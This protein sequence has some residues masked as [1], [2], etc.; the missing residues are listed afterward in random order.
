VNSAPL[1]SIVI[2]AFNPRFFQRA[3][4]GALG[5]TYAHLEVIVCD[6]SAGDEIERIVQALGATTQVDL[7][8]VRNPQRLG[9]V[10][11]VK[12]CLE[13]A[14]GEYIKFLCDDDQLFAKS[15]QTQ[16]HFLD[17]NADVNLITS[18]RLYW[19][20]DDIQLPERLENNPLTPGSAL[21]NGGDLLAVLEGFPLNFLGG[22]SSSMF[23]RRDVEELLPAL[24]TPEHGFTAALDLALYICLMRRGNVVV[25]NNILGVE[26]LHP[27]RLSRQQAMLEALD[28]ERAW[29]VQMLAARGGESAPAK[30]W[31]RYQVLSEAEHTEASPPRVWE[32][33]PI[34]RELGVRH[35]TQQWQVGSSS[36]SFQELYNAW[37]GCRTLSSK[38]QGLLPTVIS[39]WPSRPKIVVVVLD[40][41]GSR[42]AL[43]ATLHSLEEQLYAPE[44]VLVLSSDCQQARLE[45]RVFTLPLQDDPYAQLNEVLPQLDGAQWCY[46]LQAGDRLVKPAL[47]MLA[48]RVAVNTQ[49][50]CVYADEGALRE[51]ESAEP[52]FKPAFNLDLLRSYPY[53]GRALA[54][55][56]QALVG[57]EGFDARFGILAPHDALWRLFEKSGD[58]AIGHISEVMLE[59]PLSLPKWLALP[60]VAEQNLEVVQAHLNRCGI[61]HRI[62]PDD[63]L[64][65]LN[66]IEYLHAA[67][68]LVSIVL[69]VKDQLNAVQRCIETLLEK[70]D[71]TQYEL[72]LVDNG[73][74][75]AETRAW[76]AAMAQLDPALLRVLSYPQLA[77]QPDLYNAAAQDARGEYLL[78]L[79]PYVMVTHGD[80]L[81]E[82]LAQAQ[83]PEVGVVGAKLYGVEG[84]VLHAGLI[85][86]LHGPAG[87]PFNGEGLTTGGYMQR[88][89]VPS[90][91]SAVGNDCML[92][93]RQLFL[94]LGGFQD[95][96]YGSSLSHVD[97]CLRVRESGH[98]VVWTPYAL[99]ALGS[100]PMEAATRESQALRAQEQERFYMRWLPVVARDPAYSPNLALNSLGGTSFNLEPGL[101][102]GWS[103]YSTSTVPRIMTLPI[104]DS[105]IGH[106]R[107][108]Q[109]LIELEAAGRAVG[110][111]HYKTP[112][113]IEVE[114]LS[115]DI[116]VLQ[117]RYSRGR[118]AEVERFQKFSKARRIYEL[119]D[120]VINVPKKNL[121]ARNMP[122]TSE[123][124]QVV[125]HTIGL[126]DRVVVSTQPLADMLSG[127]HHD[128][129]VVPNMLAP[130]WW[131][132]LKSRRG[133]SA[134]PR[135]GWGGGTSH[136]GDLELIA[137]VVRLL[138]DEVDWV[139]FGMCP[140]SLRPYV[141]EFYPTIELADY[142]AK[143]ASLNLDLALA[144]LEQHV[145]NDCKSNLRLLEYGACGYPVICTDTLA[146]RG[147]LPC[148]RVYTN[149]TEEWLAAIRSHLD[150]P[151]ASYRQGDALRE[152]VMRDFV[153]RG[154]NLQHWVNGWLVD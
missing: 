32:E 70:T 39:Q 24:T 20:A 86:G 114:R 84:Q 112:G 122:E 8:Y 90:D 22:L 107:V 105:A 5:Q 29:L 80:W 18:Q 97:L 21:F 27:A 98:L 137:E 6:D 71:Y 36:T 109:P 147:Y 53:V 30:G 66:R 65:L 43:G 12:A 16:A 48:E 128:I 92:V 83:R 117:G 26:R 101:I 57:I 62:R 11:N 63:R 153:L 64:T 142:P 116:V 104:N 1:V 31:V 49:W 134:K 135:V 126:C 72:L 7:R 102:G 95:D 2:P 140:D 133:T 144:P 44:L 69:I 51:G 3:L 130:H 25:L 42:A 56:R 54:F 60:E 74:E 148:T 37:L 139:F 151:A 76:L 93:R 45:E 68:P 131:G 34:G 40:A 17:L 123:M 79:D 143:L 103:P 108:T 121:H 75:T 132:N 61:A 100:R 127:M 47:L 19:D 87:S 73:S 46:L 138:A 124:E 119:D 96:R 15:V 88:L 41:N 125:R 150:D 141:H 85:L 55:S 110:T 94:E 77:A 149:S 35:S 9:F 13:Q 78:H 10:G 23:R 118:I 113:I 115:P 4:Q 154:D 28:Q 67:R 129:R 152:A 146:Y 59:A 136:S 33:T 52:V 111:I 38:Q 106:Y 14:R 82:L 50:E 120:Y 58:G 145:F 81:S 91:L 89:Q 99:L